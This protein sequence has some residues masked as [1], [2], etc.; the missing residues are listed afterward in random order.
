MVDIKSSCVAIEDLTAP[1]FNEFLSYWEAARGNRI[2]P[3]W[4]DVE[5]LEMPAKVLPYLTVTEVHQPP[6][7]FIYTFYGTGHM[8]L[9]ARDLTGC[10]VTEAKPVENRP[11]VFDQYRRVL[12]AR[13]PMAFL[14]IFEGFGDGG[15]LTQASLRLPLSAD[16]ESIH[17]IMSLSD[18]GGRQDMREFYQEHGRERPVRGLQSRQRAVIA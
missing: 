16:G 4:S 8:A 3:S 1:E 13:K 10:S 17:W 18:L 15:D 6:L 12:E 7:D 2:A 9:K 5:L 14:R 11:I